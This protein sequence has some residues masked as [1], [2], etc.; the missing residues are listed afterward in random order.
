ME[1]KIGNDL[2]VGSSVHHLSSK[3]LTFLSQLATPSPSRK[4]GSMMQNNKFHNSK[5]L[6]A[7]HDKK[8]SVSLKVEIQNY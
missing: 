5:G 8:Q 3:S 6:F 1:L 2:K 7:S 4:F